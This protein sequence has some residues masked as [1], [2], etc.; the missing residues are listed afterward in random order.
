[1]FHGRAETLDVT[2]CSMP[3]HNEFERMKIETIVSAIVISVAK[4]VDA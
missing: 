2:S 1:M 3:D 4:Q